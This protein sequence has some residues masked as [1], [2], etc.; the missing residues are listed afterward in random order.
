M[1]R[2]SQRLQDRINQHIPRCIRSDKRPTKNL[3][4]RECKITSTPRIYYDSAIGQHLLENKECAK[5]FKDAQFSIL[6]TARFI[7]S[8]SIPFIPFWKHSNSIYQFWKQPTSI[9]Y[10]L[11]SAVKRN[12]FIHSK[13]HINFF[14][15]FPTKPKHYF[16][17]N[18][19]ARMTNFDQSENDKK[20]SILLHQLNT[21]LGNFCSI[22]RNN[23]NPLSFQ[24]SQPLYISLHFSFF[25]FQRRL[26]K[27]AVRKRS[28]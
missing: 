24:C 23:S 19:I 13:F 15:T 1:G 7:S 21:I 20:F 6:A 11:F 14:F 2:T 28:I 9:P 18:Q 17:T 5:H 10:S 12:S 25:S 22:L 4:N 16:S 3:P 26:M 27:K 8:R